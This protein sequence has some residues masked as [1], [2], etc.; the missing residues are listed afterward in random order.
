VCVSYNSR[1]FQVPTGSSSQRISVPS[2]LDFDCY[3]I[4]ATT[5]ISARPWHPLLCDCLGFQPSQTQIRLLVENG[6]LE[7]S[8]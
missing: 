4:K 3:R 8:G 1:S 2:F 7:V 5:F 6:A